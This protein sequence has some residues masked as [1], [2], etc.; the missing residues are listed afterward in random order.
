[1]WGCAHLQGSEQLEVDVAIPWGHCPYLLLGTPCTFSLRGFLLELFPPPG[2]PSSL[3]LLPL[4]S[5]KPNTNVFLKSDETT[6]FLGPSQSNSSFP[7]LPQC[8]AHQPITKG[9]KTAV[10]SMQALAS[11]RLGFASQLCWL[12]AVQPWACYLA[13]LSSNFFICK[14]GT[15]IPLGILGEV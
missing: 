8:V 15:V 7:L 9:Q 11:D 2:L 4:K 5:F 6:V 1:M 14:M 10:E 3:L 13:S 12:L